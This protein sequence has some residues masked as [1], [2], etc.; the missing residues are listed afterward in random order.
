MGRK[1]TPGL[2]KRGGVWH[3]DKQVRGSRLCESTGSGDLKEAETYLARRIEE[4]RQARIY[5]VRPQRIF[6]QAA[7]KYLQDA[8]QSGELRSL[9]RNAQALKLLDPY[10][11]DLPLQHVHMGTLEAYV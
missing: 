4:I 11:G 5:G 8:L 10:I 1:R 9:E 7:T 2:V 3:I 6:R